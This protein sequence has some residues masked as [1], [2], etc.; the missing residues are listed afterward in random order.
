MRIGRRECLASL[1]AG[2]LSGRFLRAGEALARNEVSWLNEVQRPPARLPADAPKLPSLLVDE[3]GQAITSLDAWQTQRNKVRQWWLDFLKLPVVQRQGPPA[4]EVLTEERAGGIVRQL[5]RYEVEPGL[6]RQAYLLKPAARPARL[7]GVVALHSTTDDTIRQPAGVRGE[8]RL[9]FGLQL[10]QRGW[11]ALCPR[12]FLWPESGKIETK[13]AV[14]EFHARNP[15]SKGMA[16]M[17]SDAMV[18]MDVLSAM[19]EVNPGRLGAVGHSLGAKEVLYLAALDDRV[20]VAVS[21]EGGI[22]T[23]FSNWDDPWYLGEEIRRPGFGHEHHELLALVAPRPFLLL[24]GDSADGDRS[25]P[26]IE[27]VLPVYKLYRGAARIGLLN[28]R[29]GHSVP[30]EAERRIHEWFAAYG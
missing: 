28:H 15:G 4:V 6:T 26:F 21:S 13:K 16:K 24:G 7:P 12:N 30:A 19:P 23:R 8:P 11:I 22:G 20:Q 9:A 14:D 2:C 5:V 29:Q 1:A 27:A 18:A 10:A 3:K 25:W 17:L